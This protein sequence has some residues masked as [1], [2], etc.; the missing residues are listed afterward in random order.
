MVEIDTAA[1]RRRLGSGVHA[2]RV[3]QGL[4]GLDLASRAA[5]ETNTVYRVENTEQDVRLSS[6][7]AICKVLGH[8]LE[9]ILAMGRPD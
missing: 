1:E 8:G 5:L 4:R 6:V 9:E 3:K 7:L 2:A